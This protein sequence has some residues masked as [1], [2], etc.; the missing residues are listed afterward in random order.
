V[1]TDSA[2]EI[3]SHVSP[4][5]DVYVVPGHVDVAGG[6]VVVVEFEPPVVVG[7]TEVYVYGYLVGSTEHMDRSSSK[8]AS[9]TLDRP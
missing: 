8:S 6:S 7:G 4:S 9:G 2:S 5:L 1:E 3:D